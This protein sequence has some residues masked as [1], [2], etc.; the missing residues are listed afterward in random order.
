[1]HTDLTSLQQA[2]ILIGHTQAASPTA[3]TT[4]ALYAL[5]DTR[6]LLQQEES[7]LQGELKRVES[8]ARLAADQAAVEQLGWGDL[9]HLAEQLAGIEAKLDRAK[10]ALYFPE[11]KG[12][13]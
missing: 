2:D 12:Y 9:G 7:Q 8:A 3:G 5:Q 10:V 11:V 1:M 13:Q 6:R 4:S